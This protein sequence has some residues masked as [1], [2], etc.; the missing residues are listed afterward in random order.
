ME[1][2]FNFCILIFVTS[3]I[4]FA[5]NVGFETEYSVTRYKSV[6][7]LFLLGYELRVNI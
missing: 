3:K 1:R 4:L 5:P 2:S 6:T 7:I